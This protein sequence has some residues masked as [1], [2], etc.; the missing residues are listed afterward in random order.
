M[1]VLDLDREDEGVRVAQQIA[2]KL[3]KVVTVRAADRVALIRVE[4]AKRSMH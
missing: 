1:M 2:T 3:Q 4:P